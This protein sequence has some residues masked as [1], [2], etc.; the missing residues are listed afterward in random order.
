MRHLLTFGPLLLIAALPTTAAVAQ[1]PSGTPG[2]DADTMLDEIVVTANRRQ[3]SLQNAPSAV[4]ALG[5]E[6]L[7]ARSITSIESVG[8]LAPGVQI[9]TYQGDTS[10][11]I[12]GIGTPTIIAGTDSST[13]SYV[14]DVYIS[15]AAAVGPAF[16][17]VA[18][19]EVLRGP[20]G[21]LYG[22]NATS[23]AFNII[24]KSPTDVL[25]GDAELILG[26]YNRV[27]FAGGVGG[28]ITD[29]I[30][31]R[32]AVQ[33]ENR[34]GFAT[35][36]R[37][38]GDLPDTQ[39]DITQ[40]VDDRNTFSV[41]A[42]IEAD[43]AP[44]TLFT[45]TA[46]Y[47][48]QKDRAN[49]YYYASAGYADEIPGWSASREGS[50]TIP[51]FAQKNAGRVTERKSRNLFSDTP[52]FSE[53]EVWGVSGRL[54]SLLA[55]HAVMLLGS[56][57]VTHPKSQNEFDLSDAF[58]NTV[59]RE[60]RHWQASADVLISSPKDN[61]FSYIVGGNYF[62][63]NNIINN[64]IFGNFWEPILRQGLADLQTAGV[65][66][67]FPIV[68]PD[69]N[70]CCDLELSGQQS[71]EA[72][73]V[74]ADTQLAIGDK[75]TLRAGGRYSRET[76]DGAQ[77]FDLLFA[78]ARFAPDAQLFP[79]AVTTSR[80]DAQTDPFGFIVAPV[81][82]PTT[83]SAFT[84]KFGVDVRPSDLVLLYA[85]AQRGFKSGG[86]NIGS[87]QREPFRPETIWSYELG[88]KTELF[89]RRLRLNFAGFYYDYS[90][91]QAQDSVSNQ[92]IIRNVGKA[93][94]KG[95]EVEA[96]ANL[97]SGIRLDGAV[98]Y[99]D[100]KFSRGALSEPLRPAPATD[101]PGSVVTDLAGLTLPRAPEWKFNVGG[102]ISRPLGNL[103]EVTARLDYVWQSKIYF[104]V[105]N[106]DSASEGA[107]GLLDARI[108]LTTNDGSWTFAVFGKN[109][110]D[111]TYFTNQILTGTVYG[112][113]F[114]GPLGAP[115]TMGISASRRF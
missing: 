100:A 39:R 46:D 80:T 21:T 47:H 112:A 51:Y 60:E 31:A 71:T 69:T 90:D 93:R 96:T 94:V 77:L 84:P 63:E 56:Y 66:P 110:G 43:L 4:T 41:R 37:P 34:D 99:L 95:V 1:A 104:T 102:E 75:V 115:R 26:N 17:D 18:R 14:D 62:R 74:F 9:S 87:G 65:I 27:Y 2:G 40:D 111:S 113:E 38:R 33:Y 15:R 59:G 16:F 83:F 73:A 57:R 92:P 107:Y 29:A 106:I 50:Q 12:R 24:T 49:T 98:T 52:Y 76:R 103:G 72:W 101:A 91:L 10:I 7:A 22:R 25:A 53:N 81:V 3:E 13:A 5:T 32:V 109:L 64:N 68:I 79:N 23:G 114:V 61:A 45:L 97:G 42:K 70:L 108:S 6:A 58:V 82:G 85:T 89:D 20:Q 78:G 55:G 54:D 36:I 19:I 35:L 86:Y 88:A 30:R 8:A 67:L 48:R 11:Y 28:P 105:F 44:D